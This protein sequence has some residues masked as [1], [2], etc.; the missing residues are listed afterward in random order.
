LIGSA[1]AMAFLAAGGQFIATNDLHIFMAMGQEMAQSGQ[2]MERDSF[3]W[4]AQGTPFIHGP[5]GFS[6]LSWWIYD[7]AGLFGLRLFNGLLAALTVALLGRAAVLRGADTRA[8]A[9]CCLFAFTLL[10]QNLAVRAQTW[11]YPLFAVLIWWVSVRR[12]P[13]A[14]WLVGVLVGCLW[15]NMHGS[16]PAGLV[17][18][19]LTGA[20]LVWTTHDLKDA[21][22]PIILAL[23]FVAGTCIGPNGPGIYG[24]VLSNSDLPQARGLSEWNSPQLL[25][26][27]GMRLTLALSLWAILIFK[28]PRALAARDWLPV[29]AFAGLALTGTRFISWFGLASAVPLAL[30]LSKSMTPSPGMPLPLL[31]RF[32]LVLS[33]FWVLFLVRGV[34]PRDQELRTETPTTAVAAIQ[35]SAPGGRI[36]NP[37]EYGGYTRFELGPNWKISSDMR[38]WIFDDAA[39]YVYPQLAQGPK[40][41]SEQLDRAGVTHLLLLPL[42]FHDGLIKRAKESPDW[43]LLAED[44]SGLSFQRRRD[45]VPATP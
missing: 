7:C 16:F 35:A 3:T 29:L 17:F 41:W 23:A 28:T 37:P 11:V 12:P 38:V 45:P 14:H 2:F 10:F 36:L 44:E 6:L 20:G 1:V 33:L 19:A 9:F 32:F 26:I 31:R 40:D 25:S 13:K 34:Q 5:W 24:F 27:S 30:R 15:A 42:P 43:K 22:T 4:T 18:L 8:A 21:K 39:W